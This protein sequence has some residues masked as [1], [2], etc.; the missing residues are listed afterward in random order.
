LYSARAGYE[1]VAEIGVPAIREKSLRL[2]RRLMDA[3]K[4]R[5]WRLN[6]PT[7]DSER[8]ASVVIDVPNGAAV[9]QELIS[10]DVIVDF[11]PGA[12]IRLAPHFYNTESEID[13]AVQTMEEITG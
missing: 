13:H 10:R 1:I 4:A 3:A 5:G 2:T 11:R 9:T 6:T 8:G 12:G 7:D